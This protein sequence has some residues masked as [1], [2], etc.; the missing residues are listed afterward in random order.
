MDEL[1]GGSGWQQ[2]LMDRAKAILMRPKETW[3]LIEGETQPISDIYRSYVIPLAAIPPVANFLR[4]SLFGYSAF[5]ITY[6]PPFFTALTSAITSYV[7]SLVSLFLIGWIIDALAPSF[8][9]TQNRLQAFK[10][11]AYAMTA[12][13]VAGILGLIPGLW[14]LAIIG[15]LYS[16][17]LVYL[18]L[19]KLMKVPENKIVPYM[20]VAALAAIVMSFIAGKVVAAITPSPMSSAIGA[21]TGGAM[22]GTLSTPGGG[23]VDLGGI[24]SAIAKAGADAKSGKAAGV[25]PEILKGLLPASLVGQARSEVSTSSAGAAGM[26]GSEVEAKYGSISLKVVDM[27]ALGAIAG[28]GAAL[29]VQSSTENADGYEK[30]GKVDGRMTSEK[31]NKT[32]SRGSYSSIIADRFMVEAEGSGTTMDTLKAA[33]ASVDAG[34]LESLAGK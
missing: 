1:Q 6:K 24:Q 11:G 18:G 33:V 4:E 15:G 8:G 3:D 29:G 9:A 28:I 30:V 20:L 12:A 13:W 21:A 7:L 2:G 32:D 14:G 19:P 31:W 10:V 34:Q 17:Y 22:G 16:I 27:S 5:G 23:S 25:D 26:G